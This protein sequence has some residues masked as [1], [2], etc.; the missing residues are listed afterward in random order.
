MKNILHRSIGCQTHF[1]MP[2][3]AIHLNANIAFKN[4]LQLERND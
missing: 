3:V 1:S 4:E 2:R